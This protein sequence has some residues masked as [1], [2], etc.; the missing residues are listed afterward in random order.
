[1]YDVILADPPWKYNQRNNLK[2]KFGGGANGHYPCM[3]LDAIKALPIGSI[4]NDNSA[5][6]LWVTMP[7]L[8]EGLEVMQ[9]WGFDYRTVAFTW[10]KTNRLNDKPFFGIGYYTKS[11][12]ELCLLGIRGRMPVVSNKVSQV[13]ISP[14]LRH[15]AKPPVVRD[16]IVELFGDTTRVELFSRD[17]V[18]GWDAWGNEVENSICMT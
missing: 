5:L 2:T 18:E 1:M 6:F 10:V 3:D 13:V 12:A 8:R 7:R 4:S 9:A 15:S 11:N 14:R 17:R 16:R